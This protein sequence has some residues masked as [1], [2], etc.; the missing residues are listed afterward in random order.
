MAV[1]LSVI[2]DGHH[3]CRQIGIEMLGNDVVVG[4]ALQ[5]EHVNASAFEEGL[6]EVSVFRATYMLHGGMVVVAIE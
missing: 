5:H 3:I 1:L 2:P 4:V 6:G